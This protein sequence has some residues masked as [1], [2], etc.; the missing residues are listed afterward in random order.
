MT[1]LNDPKMT[2]ILLIILV[3]M[4]IVQIMTLVTLRSFLPP[5]EPPQQH[6]KQDLDGMS[7][8]DMR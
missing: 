1:N 2:L 3:V 8:R 5:K 4:L 7:F 6:R